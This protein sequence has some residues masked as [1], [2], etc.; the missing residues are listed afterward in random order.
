MTDNSKTTYKPM[1]YRIY[2]RVSAAMIITVEDALHLGK[3]RFTL[4]QYTK[5]QGASAT[6]E[7]YVDTNRA[8]LLAWDLLNTPNA[9]NTARGDVSLWWNGYSEFKG[10]PK[11]GELQARTFQIELATASKNPVRFTIANG[12]GEPVGTNGAIKPKEGAKADRVSTVLPWLDVREMALALLMHLQAWQTMTYYH[13][14]DEGT[15]HP[16]QDPQAKTATVDLET[17]EITGPDPRRAIPPQ[18]RRS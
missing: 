1:F 13:R 3:I 4:T 6:V 14:R 11:D 17:G 18:D 8:A 5:G 12:P 9:A 10:S 15:W 2:R 7:H 16:D